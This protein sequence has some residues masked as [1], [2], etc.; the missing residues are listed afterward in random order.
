MKHILK[1]IVIS[2]LLLETSFLFADGD[3]PFFRYY[4]AYGGFGNQGGE[5]EDSLD[6]VYQRHDEGYGRRGRFDAKSDA[7]LIEQTPTALSRGDVGAEGIVKGPMAAWFFLHMPSVYRFK[8]DGESTVLLPLPDGA[9]AVGVHKLEQAAGLV[10]NPGQISVEVDRLKSQHHALR[11]NIDAAFDDFEDRLEVSL[12]NAS[13]ACSVDLSEISVIDL[14]TV[15]SLGSAPKFRSLGKFQQNAL[16]HGVGAL[17]GQG[18]GVAAGYLAG[19]YAGWVVG[20]S[21]A[22]VVGNHA[23]KKWTGRGLNNW[24]RPSHW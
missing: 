6:E 20:T 21:T 8:P 11:K 23:K 14:S 4:G 13:V 9:S 10:K 1:L 18:T 12:P 19:P 3:R 2:I 24:R 5:P 7:I 16:A 15:K 22:I 17:A